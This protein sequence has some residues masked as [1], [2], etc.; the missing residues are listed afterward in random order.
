MRKPVILTVDDDPEVLQA[1]S[2]DLR[3]AYGDKFRIVR[4][5]SGDRAL[6]VL[7]KVKLTDD[8]VALFLVDQRMPGLSGVDFL[9][10]HERSIQMRKAP[11]SP[12]TRT[13]MRRSRQ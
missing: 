11:F 6:D 7:K 3:K 2:Q 1:I 13:L 4:V 12:P 8:P 5:D 9:C 10:R